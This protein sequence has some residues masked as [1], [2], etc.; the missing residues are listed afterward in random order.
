MHVICTLVLLFT[1]AIGNV[2]AADPE[3]VT[4]TFTNTSCL[5]NQTYT[6]YGTPTSETFGYASSIPVVDIN[7][8]NALTLTGAIYNNNNKNGRTIKYDSSKGLSLERPGAIYFTLPKA[9]TSITINIKSKAGG[10]GAA[11]EAYNAVTTSNLLTCSGDELGAAG[12]SGGTFTANNVPA[13][14]YKIYSKQDLSGT[15]SWGIVSIVIT[16]P[17]ASCE[18]PGTPADLAVDSKTYNSATFSWSAAA[19]SDGYKVYVEKKSDKSKILD[20]TTCAT[21]SYTATGL[22]AETEYTFKVKAIGASGYCEL[23]DEATVDVTTNAAPAACPA[24]LAISG[25]AAYSEGETSSL[26]AALSEGNGEITYNWYKGADLAT[27]N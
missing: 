26:T 14:N 25:T 13:G 15:S 10:F 9:A 22:A 11:G 17:A 24:G 23:G 8:K 7:G 18:K 20:W 5:A 19:N 21:T 16:Y 3:V 1:F 2:W 4:Y 12:S 27:A 6:S